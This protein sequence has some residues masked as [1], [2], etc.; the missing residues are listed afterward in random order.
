MDDEKLNKLD[1]LKKLLNKFYELYGN[2]FKNR[3]L[4]DNNKTYQYF[5]ARIFEQFQIEYQV[6]R[7]KFETIENPEIYAARV[8][9]GL[10]VPRRRFGIFRNRAQKLIDRKVTQ[11][12]DKYFSKQI[13]A[14]ERLNKALD[15]A[16]SA[17]HRPTIFDEPLDDWEEPEN[18]DETQA[19][20]S[21]GEQLSPTDKPKD[22][23]NNTNEIRS[24]PG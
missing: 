17:E 19:G 9:H 18:A 16:D 5:G 22:S 4:L 12:I 11:E 23:A 1:E 10:L 20:A 7:I 24:E 13:E 14:L 8:I 3:K 15:K 2:L 21:D 6:L